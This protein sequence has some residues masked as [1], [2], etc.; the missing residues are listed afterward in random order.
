[1]IRNLYETHLQVSNLEQSIEFYKKLGLELG[2]TIEE[3]RCAFFYIGT[4]RQM[5]GLWEISAGAQIQRNH[6]AFGVEL[7][8]LRNGTEWLRSLDIEPAASFG[9]EPLEPMV[10]TWMPAAS[11]YFGD[12]DRN[13]LELIAWLDGE[14]TVTEE[15][16]YLSE[17]EQMYN[18]K[19]LGVVAYMDPTNE[20][21]VISVNPA[22]V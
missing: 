17:W 6:F 19:N 1:M 2:H 9:K 12:P 18:A 16:P 10:H 15:V 21:I 13:S 8:D 7:E 20:D 3:R 14:P 22:S 4:E 11:I 5:L